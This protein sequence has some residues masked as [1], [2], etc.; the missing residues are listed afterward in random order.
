VISGLPGATKARYEIVAV[1]KEYLE[2][3]TAEAPKD[4]DLAL[5]MGVAYELLARVQG[6]PTA[7]NLGLYADAA[8]SLRK[9]EDLL[10]SVLAVS[11]RNRQALLASGD[12][13][14]SRVI[15]ADANHRRDEILTQSAKAVQRLGVLRSLGKL[16]ESESEMASVVFCNLALAHKN[17][18][19][20]AE[21]AGLSRQAIEI[22]RQWAST[23]RV[24]AQAMT[25]LADSLR[26]SGDLEGALQTIRESLSVVEDAQYGTEL[27]RRSAL[28]SAYWRE[29]VILGQ[30][31]LISLGRLDDAVL[32]FQ[33]ALDT[34][35]EL[36]R[37]DPNESSCRFLVASASRELG[38][39]LRNRDA[40]RAL[41]VYDHALLRLGEIINNAKARRGEA[42]ILAGSSYAL[43]RLH[44]FEDARMRIDAAFRRLRDTKDYPADRIDL[45][46]EADTV[47]RAL[48]DHLAGTGQAPRATEVYQE[49]LEKVLATKP[50]PSADLRH[51]AKLSSI[52][53]VLAGLDH[54]V[55]EADRAQA[56]SKRR[57]ELWQQW[58]RKL[59]DNHYVVGQLEAA[60]AAM[61]R[62]PSPHPS[63]RG[64][65]RSK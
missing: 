11:P 24:Y 41:A 36:A 28:S 52:Y 12:V 50:D 53:Q 21:A 39:V 33:K 2:G 14:Q 62:D 47:L 45:G 49:L 29:G 44:R 3:L 43:R 17:I 13:A 26:L 4:Q 54:R 5:E 58:D 15:L 51:A 56:L 35:E 37:R 27:T 20:S 1:S 40:R 32:A 55:G 25:I 34:A 31:G 63:E 18:H 10:A 42:E 8:E 6:V 59:A 57:L 16:S 30:E 9:A 65:A 23:R 46:S 22:S 38:E 48:G 64:R 61:A 7:S 60:R 19:L